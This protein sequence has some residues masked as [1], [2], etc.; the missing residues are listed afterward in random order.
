[1]PESFL[2]D[3]SQVKFFDI[4]KPLF[5]GKKTGR[6]N[7]KGKENGEICLD[8]GD[9]VHSRTDHFIGENAFFTIMGWKAGRITFEPDVFLKERTIP[10]TTEQLLLNWSSRK[11]EFEKIREVIPSTHTFFRLSLQRDGKEKNISAD[12]WDVLVL[13]NGMKTISEIATFLE[14]EEYKVLKAVYQLVQMGLLERGEDRN[15]TK[16]K[17]VKDDFFPVLETELK[18]AMGP[19]APFIV[20][21]K[22]VEFGENRGS[23]P[24]E[25]ALP[26]MEALSEEIPNPLKRSEFLNATMKLLSL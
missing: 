21:D 8:M 1:M 2:G 3:L 9:I 26:F 24:Q 22:L 15:P 17:P 10:I 7:I 13:C 16:K 4:L 11:Q 12:Q 23:F 20:D 6:V 18:R 19:V 14:W 5:T 25:R